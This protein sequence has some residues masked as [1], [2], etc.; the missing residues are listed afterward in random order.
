MIPDHHDVRI[1]DENL[2]PIDYSQAY[3]LVGVTVM[4][5]LAVQA[6][7]IAD[8]FRA[9]G[10]TVVLGGIH[11]S[12]RPKEAKE[13][14]DA[15][16][17]GE[18]ETYFSR[19]IADAEAGRLQPFYRNEGF[20][21]M[22][23][24]PAPRKSLLSKRYFF[25]GTVQTTRGC[26]FGCEFCSVTAFFGRTYR[27]KAIHQV[28]AELEQEPSQ[29]IFFVDDNITGD[30]RFAKELFTA[31]APLKKKWLSQSSIRIADDDELLNLAAASGCRGLFIGFESLDEA[32]L[33]LMGKTMNRASV[34]ED[35]IKKIQDKGI[36]IQ[37]SFIFGYDNDTPKSFDKILRFVDRSR[38]DAALFSVLTP[39]PGTGIFTRLEQEKRILSYDW[40]KY[41][42][43]TVVFQPKGMSPD[44]LQRHFNQANDHLYSMG[45]MFR[46]LAKWHRSMQ[47]FIPQ[48]IGFRWAWK[49]ARKYSG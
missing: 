38:L 29:F 49:K 36:G 34:Y 35:K 27:K 32:N 47:V 3:D 41:D 19:L 10:S 46:R 31:I 8:R 22:Q 6:Y 4:T 1:I 42:M 11:A 25:K 24:I 39:F 20:C 33:N 48:N 12:V 44:T 13:H 26:P 40:E 28:L 37:G 21:D 17:V 16:A 7:R 14:C 2:Q 43:Y 45:S 5:P 30:K 18:S 23:R 15:V 9:Q